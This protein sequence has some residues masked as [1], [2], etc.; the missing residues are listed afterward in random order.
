V[1]REPSRS[2]PRASSPGQDLSGIAS[3]ASFFVSRVDTEVDRRLEKMGAPAAAALRGQ[4]AI[5][6]ARLA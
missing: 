2:W 4:A 1:R 6:N 5:A 3:V